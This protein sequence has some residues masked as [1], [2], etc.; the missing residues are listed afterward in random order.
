MK[1]PTGE[2]IEWSKPNINRVAIDDP[3]IDKRTQALDT[4]WLTAQ[5]NRDLARARREVRLWRWVAGAMA[6]VW[7]ATVVLL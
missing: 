6:A 7:A 3:L 5:L 4:L 2:R 1:M